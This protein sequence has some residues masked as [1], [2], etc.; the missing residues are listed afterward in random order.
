MRSDAPVLLPILRSQHQADLLT[1]VL[2][3]PDQEYTVT[4]LAARLGIAQSTISGEVQRLAQAGIVTVRPVG[5][6]RLVRANPASRLAAPLTEL[7]TVTYG[8]HVVIG[9]EF[10]T[11]PRVDAVVIYG[12]WAARYHGQAGPPPHDVDVL[13]VGH[14]DRTAMH[15]AA[16]RAEDRLS[17]PVNPVAVTPQRWSDAAEP[18][19]QEIKANPTLLVAGDP[20]SIAK[21][22]A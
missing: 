10:G 21:E 16:A 12:S 13:V 3:H 20:A 22:T 19:I 17:L 7:V 9:D 1:L 2:L 11:L 15:Q 6:S 4:E 14:P 5:R 8:P 18:L